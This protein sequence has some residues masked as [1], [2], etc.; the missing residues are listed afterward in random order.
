M[1]VLGHTKQSCSK[2]KWWVPSEAWNCINNIIHTY[3]YISTYIQT[4]KHACLFVYLLQCL[5][6]LPSWVFQL[7]CHCFFLRNTFHFGDH[8]VG[9]YKMQTADCR[10]GTKCRLSINKYVMECHFTCTCITYLVSWNHH[11][12]WTL[13][14]LWNILACFLIDYVLNRVARPQSFLNK[15]SR[16]LLIC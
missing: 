15:I 7:Q 3:K 14:L 5:L 16:C 10:P 8:M 6:Q 9:Q 12:S 4:N 2:I 1:I 11:F 13:A